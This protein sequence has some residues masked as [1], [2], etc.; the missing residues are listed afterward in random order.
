MQSNTIQTGTGLIQEGRRYGGRLLISL[1]ATAG[2]LL[3]TGCGGGSAGGVGALDLPGAD[4]GVKTYTPPVVRP[5]VET[6]AAHSTSSA[7]IQR[8]L[9]D[10]Y[11]PVRSRAGTLTYQNTSL[12]Q[13]ANEIAAGVN[14]ARLGAGLNSLIVEPNLSKVAQAHARDMALRDYFGHDTPDGLTPWN[15]LSAAGAPFYAKAAENAAKGQ[16]TTAEVVSGWLSSPRHRENM[17][18]PGL[19]HMGIGVYFDSSDQLMPVHVIVDFTEFSKGLDG[20][21]W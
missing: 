1:L 8:W 21:T 7:P 5:E 4:G 19:T 15:R 14:S 13:W 18:T 20:A 3:A 11:A 2:A 17:L 16:E 9:D 12:A 6:F 10:V